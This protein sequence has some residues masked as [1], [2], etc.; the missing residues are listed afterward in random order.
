MNNENVC[1][2]FAVNQ[3]ASISTIKC[4]VPELKWDNYKFWRERIV[5]HLDWMDIDYVIRKNESPGITE[6]STLNVV[7]L[8]E[9]GERSNCLSVMFIK[10]NIFASICSSI[11]QH[12][13]INNLLK[14]IDDQFITSDKAFA[15]TLIMHFS[16]LKL[17]RI[18]GVCDHIMCMRDIMAQLKALEVTMLDFFLIHYILCTLPMQ[19]VPF[20]ISH[21][22]HK[23]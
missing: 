18:R 21:N 8:Y 3:S 19:Y 12:E 5:L 14:V 6:T 1:L 13:K 4:D 7:D 11:D 20:K 9:K 2:N 15:S 17:Y 16:S 10:I 22:T 23:D